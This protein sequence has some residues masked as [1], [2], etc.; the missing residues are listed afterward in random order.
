MNRT[1][2]DATVKRFHYDSHEQLRRHLQDF[3]AAYNFARRLKRLRGLTHYEFLQNMGSRATTLHPKSPP[4]NA[5][6]KHPSLVAGRL[7]A[8]PTAEMEAEA[9]ASG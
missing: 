3:V 6:I 7:A 1:I 2:K 4:P 9:A 5:G 8:E